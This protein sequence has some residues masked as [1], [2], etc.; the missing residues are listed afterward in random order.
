[1]RKAKFLSPQACAFLELMDPDFSRCQ[2]ADQAR[3]LG[4]PRV[5]EGIGERV[6]FTGHDRSF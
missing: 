5:A 4:G 6:D 2:R 1:M 3:L